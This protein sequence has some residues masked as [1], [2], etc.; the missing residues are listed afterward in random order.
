MFTTNTHVDLCPPANGVHTWIME[1]AWQCRKAGLS[2]DEAV[3][4]IEATEPKLRQGR[5]FHPKEVS[6]A[7]C[8]VYSSKVAQEA[9]EKIGLP[10]YDPKLTSDIHNALKTTEDDLRQDSPVP[11]ENLTAEGL[12]GTL[13]PGDPLLCCGW[14]NS[15]FQTYRRSQWQSCVRACQFIVPTVMLAPTGI[16]QDGKESAHTKDNTGPRMYVVLDFDDPPSEQHASLIVHLAQYAQLTLALKSGG[17]SL[18]AWFTG[19]SDR[20][21]LRFFTYAA[22]CGA[23]PVLWRN[24]SQFVR[25]PLGHRDQQIL[26][27][28]LYFNPEYCAKP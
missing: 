14:T 3:K 21:M 11:V 16:T 28:V 24:S 22:R 5:C 2:E 6:G 4:A 20:E 15:N 26:Q 19:G 27:E 25:L 23:D 18:H 7:V 17:K 1:A 8:K 9:K 10:A 12:L 13:F